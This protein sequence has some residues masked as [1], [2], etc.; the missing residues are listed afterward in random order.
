MAFSEQ[1]L[2]RMLRDLVEDELAHS[3]DRPDSAGWSTVTTLDGPEVRSDS[4]DLTT[5]AT[6]VNER[7]RLHELRNEDFLL[8]YRT[9]GDW[10]G[11]VREALLEGTAGMAFRTSGTTGPAKLISHGWDALEA[12]LRA[13]ERVLPTPRRVIALVPAHNIYGFLLTV[14][15]PERW[16]VPV[17]DGEA[18][19]ATVHA[20]LQPGDLVVTIPERWRYLAS[21]R[22]QWPEAVAGVSSTAHLDT[23]V[24]RRLLDSGI[25]AITEI[26]GAT[27]TGGAGYRQA[28]GEAFTL[29]PHWQRDEQGRLV[30]TSGATGEPMVPMDQ[31]R[32]TGQRQ[33]R[34]EERY[35][36]AVSVGGTNVH[37]EAVGEALC[38]HPWVQGAQVAAQPSDR[39]VRLRAHISLANDAPDIQQAR[40]VLRQ[41]IDERFDPSR[42]PRALTFDQEAGDTGIPVSRRP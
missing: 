32:W 4:L 15:L 42:R 29:L 41:W 8:R 35:D 33:F 10:V 19:W 3:G 7:F 21:V 25:E 13:L 1:S 27:E 36:G 23:T 34:P 22:G 20:D 6:A 12:E 30:P 31:L 16:G 39:G 9:L 38:E 40:A 2:F 28:P 24:Y 17:V 37:P 11:L 5:L 18:A 26:Y 14:A